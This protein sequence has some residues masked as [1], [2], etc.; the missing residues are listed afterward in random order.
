MSKTHSNAIA[1]H[2]FSFVFSTPSSI[3]RTSSQNSLDDLMATDTTPQVFPLFVSLWSI[4]AS[5]SSSAQNSCEII[6]R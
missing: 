1:H 2:S 4:S 3:K 5:S 6:L